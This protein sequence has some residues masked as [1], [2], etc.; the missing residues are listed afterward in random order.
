MAFLTTALANAYH[1]V[2]Q[3]LRRVT[4][5]LSECRECGHPVNFFRDDI[6]ERCG[7]GKPIRINISPCVLL[8]AA[9]CELTLLLLV[10][11]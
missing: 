6:C 5:E 11:V 3:Y 2:R 9:G 1:A 8:T 10:L 7:V 4:E